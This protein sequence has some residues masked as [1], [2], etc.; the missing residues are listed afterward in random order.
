LGI[1]KDNKE[2]ILKKDRVCKICTLD[3]RATAELSLG[4]GK[5]K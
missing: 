5:I 3:R 4:K 1:D 2:S